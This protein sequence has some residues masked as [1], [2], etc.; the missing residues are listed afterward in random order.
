VE[1]YK[2]NE[3]EY[4]CEGDGQYKINAIAEQIDEG[5]IEMK[6]NTPNQNTENIREAMRIDV[7]WGGEIPLSIGKGAAEIFEATNAGGSPKL[8]IDRDI[9]N[10]ATDT[11]DYS[12]FAATLPDGTQNK[13]MEYKPVL[14]RLIDRQVRD[15]NSTSSNIYA[16]TS[17]GGGGTGGG[18][19]VDIDAD[20]AP[21]GSLTYFNQ[22]QGS[23][24]SYQWG[25]D[26]TMLN[27]GCGPTS[28]AMIINKVN[29]MN[30]YGVATSYYPGEDAGCDGTADTQAASAFQAAGLSASAI[31]T[32][33]AEDIK[34]ALC[35]GNK[36][37]MLGAESC[38]TSDCSSTIKHW[39]LVV[40]TSQTDNA[41]IM[42]DPYYSS[43]T[44]Q[45]LDNSKNGLGTPLYYTGSGYICV[46]I[47]AT[48]IPH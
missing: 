37:V 48:N 6:G 43:N 39:M 5:N 15:G 40:G 10:A 41:F 26:C 36:L 38:S 47:D 24:A 27:T 35:D 19:S 32:C 17:G 31:G 12:R 14:V 11:L 2:Y 8:F 29:G 1:Y 30:P 13:P 20:C 22:T 18:T 3:F 34:S 21:A 46:M 42:M 9:D 44:S 7:G 16:G 28:A 4:T 33:N 25:P 45:K 23:W